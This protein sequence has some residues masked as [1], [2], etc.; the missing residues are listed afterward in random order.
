MFG[1]PSNTWNANWRGSMTT[2]AMSPSIIAAPNRSTRDASSL[3]A[4]EDGAGAGSALDAGGWYGL[5]ASGIGPFG[6]RTDAP[7][8]VTAQQ[9][10]ST[11]RGNASVN[12]AP[13]LRQLGG[14]YA[15]TQDQAANYG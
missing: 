3:V 14:R 12:A 6:A 8:T 11:I 5:K 15:G 7:S 1:K 9:A 13:S 10:R 4:G 2:S